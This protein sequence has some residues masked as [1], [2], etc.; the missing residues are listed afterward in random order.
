MDFVFNFFYGKPLKSDL[1]CELRGWGTI[2]RGERIQIVIIYYRLYGDGH[3]SKCDGDQQGKVLHGCKIQLRDF[4]WII[5]GRLTFMHRRKNTFWSN[6]DCDRNKNYYFWIT[7]SDFMVAIDGSC[8]FGK[9]FLLSFFR[10]LKRGKFRPNFI[11]FLRS[12]S[13]ILFSTFFLPFCLIRFP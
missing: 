5:K 3:W 7:S 2:K 6:Q 8:K 10:S 12:L 9:F 13:L 1:Q 11:G 4:H